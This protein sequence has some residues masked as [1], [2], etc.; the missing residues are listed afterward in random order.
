MMIAEKPL[1]GKED[2]L[3]ICDTDHPLFKTAKNV[4]KT[5]ASMGC[6]IKVSSS[7]SPNQQKLLEQ[8]GL[9]LIPTSMIDEQV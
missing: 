3:S 5:W 7:S 1:I 8:E 9:K 6:S 4:M 2:S